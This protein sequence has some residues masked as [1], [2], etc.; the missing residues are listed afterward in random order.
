MRDTKRFLHW[1]FLTC[2]ILLYFISLFLPALL[3]AHHEPLFGGYVLA[4]GWWGVLT[5]DF[6]WFANLT[7]A[8]ALIS[9]KDNNKWL[10]KQVC[11]ITIVLGLTSYFTKE[12]WF[13]EATG[14]P[15]KGLGI[16]YYVWMLSFSM[17]LLGCYLAS[18]PNPAVQGTLRDK[19]AQ[20]P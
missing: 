10:S 5:F 7:Y 4:W 19:A 3:F 6:A 2:S 11:N 9:Y 16:G 13:T 15:I 17:L 8:L 12:W 20:R 1:F 18:T 14:A